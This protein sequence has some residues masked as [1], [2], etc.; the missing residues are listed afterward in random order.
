MNQVPSDSLKASWLIHQGATRAFLK[1]AFDIAGALV[2]LIMAMPL[3]LLTAIA[4]GLDSPGP[5]FHRRECVG[6]RGEVFPCL[7]FRSMRIEAE[8][9]DVARCAG[10]KRARFHRGAA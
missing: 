2:L 4:V 10:S 6:L 1:R 8:C 3:M 9:D 5:V 7:K